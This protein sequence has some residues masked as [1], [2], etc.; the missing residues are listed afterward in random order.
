MDE[1]RLVLLEKSSIKNTT[2][3]KKYKCPYC[4]IR[5]TRVNLVSHILDNHEELIPKGYTANRVVFNTVN[6]K[7]HGSCV[8]CRKETKW[9]EDK[10]RYDR[11][12]DNKKCHDTYVKIAH[13][14]TGIDDKLKD[15]EFQ[16]KML[17]GRGISGTYKFSDGGVRSYVGSYEKKFLEFMDK[18]LR[19]KSKD[20]M[21]PGPIVEYDFKGETHTWITDQYYIPYNLVF[22]IKDGGNNP[23]TREMPEYRAKQKAK[24]AAIKKQGKY[25]YIR[26]TDND[27]SQLIAIMLELKQTFG[28]SDHKKVIHINEMATVVANALPSRYNP[29][30]VYVINYMMNTVFSGPINNQAICRDGMTDMFTF[31][32]GELQK[33]N[34]D[35]LKEMSDDIK[36]YK[37]LGE[38]SSYANI[39]NESNDTQSF[40]NTLTRDDLDFDDIDSDYRFEEVVPTCKEYD[41]LA[42][43]VESTIL[44][45]QNNT[46]K[47]LK[48]PIIEFAEIEE[49]SG[50][51]YCRDLN[52]IF[53]QNSNIGIRSASYPTKE[54]IPAEE[55]K[56]VCGK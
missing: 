18:F 22:D 17:A 54:D 11:L 50:I 27:F 36:M 6:K 26:L 40:Y 30:N 9:D 25:N 21:S 34:M 45:E 14:N 51:F 35:D 43:C 2:Y 5:D 38:H 31:I 16:N 4:E 20:I 55:K 7:D 41:A 23:N 19:V 12:C 44:Q 52:G 8:I 37:Y 29:N 48:I 46:V 1:L 24:E 33:I 53:L 13:E 3:Q 28:E 15:P 32:N 42:R 56:I 47:D 49:G 10:C 39:L